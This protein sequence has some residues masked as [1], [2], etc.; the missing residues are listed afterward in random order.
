MNFS[1][2]YGLAV[3]IDILNVQLQRAWLEYVLTARKGLYANVYGVS[4]PRSILD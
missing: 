2:V 3:L 4:C 1:L